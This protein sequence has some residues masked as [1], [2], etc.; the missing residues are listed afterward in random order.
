MC[1]VTVDLVGEKVCKMITLV[2]YYDKGSRHITRYSS[3]NDCTT[4]AIMDLVNDNILQLHAKA[5]HDLNA[6]A[7]NE[8]G[9]HDCADLN[10]SAG[11]DSTKITK[12]KT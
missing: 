12:A 6:P 8:Q 7:T 11:K 9:V 2:A 3:L 1:I 4:V 10:N 5:N